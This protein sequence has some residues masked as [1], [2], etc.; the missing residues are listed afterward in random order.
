MPRGPCF[1][2]RKAQGAKGRKGGER[3]C[4]PDR[5]RLIK[6]PWHGP[7]AQNLI[8]KPELIKGRIPAAAAQKGGR[9]DSL[10]VPCVRMATVLP[11]IG[12]EDREAQA[13]EEGGGLVGI[14]IGGKKAL[15][16]AAAAAATLVLL[17]TFLIIL[18]L[19]VF[20]PPRPQRQ[21]C[22]E[23]IYTRIRL[24]FSILFV[25]T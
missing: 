23:H 24:S 12:G 4:P 5:L 8:A 13:A 11:P 7:F 21:A 16:G 9:R 1:H 22:R 3:N 15:I 18:F 2:N 19:I 14:K 10:R 17:I 6:G 25:I 20:P